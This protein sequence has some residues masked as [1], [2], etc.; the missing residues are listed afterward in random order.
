MMESKIFE[1]RDCGTFIP[2]LVTKLDPETNAERYLARRAG[3]GSGRPYFVFW[4]LNGGVASYDPYDLGGDTLAV[5]ARHI[6]D[7]W[8]EL[9]PGAVVDVEFLRGERPEPKTSERLDGMAAN[10]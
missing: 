9:E 8:S 2:L 10:A 5:A 6:Q 1:V 4:R 3:F 7:H